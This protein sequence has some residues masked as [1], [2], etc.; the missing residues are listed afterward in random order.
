MFVRGD[1]FG[2]I[3]FLLLILLSRIGLYGFS[4][5]EMQIRQIGV[6]PNVRGEVNGFANA[7]TALATIGLFATGVALPSTEQFKYLV[8]SS[9]GFVVMALFVYAHWYRKQIAS[10]ELCRQAKS[11]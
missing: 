8:L 3:G 2:Q 7:L 5:G 10:S 1:N 9:A 11:L 4:L 6:A